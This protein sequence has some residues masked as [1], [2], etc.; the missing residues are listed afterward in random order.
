MKFADE[1]PITGR[2][3]YCSGEYEVDMTTEVLDTICCGFYIRLIYVCPH[4][5]EKHIL[6]LFTDIIAQEVHFSNSYKYVN[7]ASLLYHTLGLRIVEIGEDDEDYDI[8]EPRYKII[9]AFT[10][11]RHFQ[12][13]FYRGAIFPVTYGQMRKAIMTSLCLKYLNNEDAC[14]SFSINILKKTC[15]L[16][17]KL[18]NTTIP[19][20]INYTILT[21]CGQFLYD[22]EVIKCMTQ[23]DKEMLFIFVDSQ[24]IEYNVQWEIVS[25]GEFNPDTYY[26]TPV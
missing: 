14:R 11:E 17:E 4:C 6:D 24:A 23:A 1:N 26:M 9:N 5:G 20:E 13:S 25:Q 18:Q 22:E 21:I 12:P 15:K 10:G 7:V 2:C 8:R 16:L 3:P 19:N